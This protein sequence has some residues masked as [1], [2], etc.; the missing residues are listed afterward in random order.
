MP[1]GI[2]LGWLC[3]RPSSPR[4]PSRPARL[5][6]DVSASVRD[7]WCSWFCTKTRGVPSKVA[8]LG[9]HLRRRFGDTP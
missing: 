8:E 5:V 4:K 2:G 1:P 9:R 7:V 6:I 3:C